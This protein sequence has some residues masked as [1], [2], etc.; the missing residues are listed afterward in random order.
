MFVDALKKWV[1]SAEDYKFKLYLSCFNML[2]I[3]QAQAA[4]IPS[5]EAAN[6]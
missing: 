2:H 1:Q 6:R 3:S 4:A 5:T